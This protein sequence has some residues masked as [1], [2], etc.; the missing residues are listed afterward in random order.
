M[1]SDG[2]K[3]DLDMI[4]ILYVEDDTTLCQLFEVVMA[5]HGYAVDVATTGADGLSKHMSNL[6]DIV[7]L[8]HQ[9]LDMTGLDIA[10]EILETDPNLPV[11]MI[12]GRAR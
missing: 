10:R 7:A 5:L 1:G 11:L 12:T 6:Y 4:R 8:D 3:A 9:L 2:A